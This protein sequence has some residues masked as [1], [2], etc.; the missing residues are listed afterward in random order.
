MSVTVYVLI[1]EYCWPMSKERRQVL[2]GPWKEEGNLRHLLSSCGSI[3]SYHIQVISTDLILGV[4]KE[5]LIFLMSCT[6]FNKCPVTA[7]LVNTFC[8]ICFASDDI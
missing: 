8:T 3:L 7:S 4:D 1:G 2:S 5:L 6:L